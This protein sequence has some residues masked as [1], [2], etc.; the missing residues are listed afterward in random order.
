MFGFIPRKYA[1][2]MHFFFKNVI[3]KYVL[4]LHIH[5]LQACGV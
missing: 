4:F 3:R 2:G 1:T 5:Y